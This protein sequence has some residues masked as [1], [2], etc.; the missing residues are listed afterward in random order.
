MAARARI[1]WYGPVVKARVMAACVRA[2]NVT[3][4]GCV[5]VAQSRAAVDTGYMRA[6]IFYRPA[7]SSGDRIVGTWGASAG[8][9]IYVEL[10]TYR[11]SAQPFIRPAMDSQYPKLPGRIKAA[12]S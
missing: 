6:S 7:R 11:M 4:A 12:Y 5:S 10:G 2:I 9:S 1:R 3:L 8:Y